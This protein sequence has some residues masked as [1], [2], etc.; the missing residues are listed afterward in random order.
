MGIVIGDVV[1]LWDIE[2][3]LEIVVFLVNCWNSE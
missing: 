3:M 1:Y 2:V